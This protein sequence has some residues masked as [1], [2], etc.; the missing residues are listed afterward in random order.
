MPQEQYTAKG[1]A[2]T[3]FEMLNERIVDFTLSK[4]RKTVVAV[5]CCDYWFEMELSKE[6]LA[7]VIAGLQEIH[8]RMVE[9]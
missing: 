9:A 2:M 4:D 5:E 8:A 3:A 6:D 1:E 7:N